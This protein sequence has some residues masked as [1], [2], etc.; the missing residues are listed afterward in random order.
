[1]GEGRTNGM[2]LI[3]DIKENEFGEM[4][5]SVYFKYID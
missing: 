3:K 2:E 4:V 1:M 5:G